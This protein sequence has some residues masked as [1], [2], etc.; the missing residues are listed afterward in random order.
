MLTG[1]PKPYGMEIPW[2]TLL[3]YLFQ[4]RDKMIGIYKITKIYKK[5]EQKWIN[6]EP[7]S[8]IS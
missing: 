3:I 6:N 2:E 7:V 1:N 4:R 5:K 8:T